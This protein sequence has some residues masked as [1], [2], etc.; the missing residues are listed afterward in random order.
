MK[1]VLWTDLFQSLL[2]YIAMIS[3]VVV[4]TY[5]LGGLDKVWQEA[6]EGGRIEFFK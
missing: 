2:M 1:A 5:N 6:Q 3:V 4:G